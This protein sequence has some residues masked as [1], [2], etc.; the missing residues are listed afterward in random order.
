[1]SLKGA[2]G[3]L[4]VRF[5]VSCSFLV[6]KTVALRWSREGKMPMVLAKIKNQ[7]DRVELSSHVSGLYIYSTEG[8]GSVRLLLLTGKPKQ[9]RGL[10]LL[11]GGQNRYYNF[12]TGLGLIL[13]T[14][15]QKGTYSQRTYVLYFSFLGE[16]KQTRGCDFV[17]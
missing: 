11:A 13:L 4:Q 2:V 7:V 3:V 1:M 10:V 16:Q 8:L 14:R 6:P 15:K 5:R 12:C 17:N 9:T